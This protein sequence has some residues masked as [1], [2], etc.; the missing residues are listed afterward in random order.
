VYSFLNLISPTV[1]P[2]P[3]KIPISDFSLQ[4]VT[5]IKQIN[6]FSLGS[7]F[8]IP[9]SIIKLIIYPFL[10][11]G[12]IFYSIGLEIAWVFSS[13]YA[14]ISIFPPFIQNIIYTLL[15]I[16][17]ILL[18]IHSLKVLESGIE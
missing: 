5:G 2:P 9:A 1:L 15:P 10:F 4:N 12:L 17:I 7:F 14:I 13:I 3:P 6:D 11:L 16:T 8:T 18:F